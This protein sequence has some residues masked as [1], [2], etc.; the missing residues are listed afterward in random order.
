MMNSPFNNTAVLQDRHGLK[1]ASYLHLGT[2]ELPRE[3]TERLRVARLQAL[4]Q[5][6]ANPVKAAA[7]TQVTGNKLML[8]WDDEGLNWWNKIGSVVPLVGLVVGLVL[9]Q[10]TQNDHRAKE[11]AEVDTALLIDELPVAA[12]ADPGF[13]QFLKTEL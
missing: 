10:A 12:F 13:L 6:K 9:I 5:R 4:A 2:N 8:N 3:I 1:L 11:L 7:T